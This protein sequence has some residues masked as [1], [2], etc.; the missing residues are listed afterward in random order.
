[1]CAQD[2]SPPN[3]EASEEDNFLT[4]AGGSADL[5]TSGFSW[6]SELLQVSRHVGMVKQARTQRILPVSPEP[7]KL[8]TQRR[9]QASL[10]TC[11][12]SWR[13][14]MPCDGQ[15][16]EDRVRLKYSFAFAKKGRLSEFQ[17]NPGPLNPKPQTLNPKP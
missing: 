8:L 4:E 12:S 14:R 3:F 5:V 7:K 11:R 16:L 17:Q 2:L 1:M 6:L 15:G 13:R 9:R 10:P